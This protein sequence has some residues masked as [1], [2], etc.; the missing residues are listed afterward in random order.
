MSTFRYVL[1]WFYWLLGLLCA[2]VAV[3][4]L[5]RFI[6]EPTPGKPPTLDLLVSLG[7][8]G[9]I[10]V[11]TF[12]YLMA[13]WVLRGNSISGK[14]WVIVASLINL[15][16]ALGFSFLF[17]RI[18][19]AAGLW[20]G[21]K[22]FAIPAAFGI[23][24]LFAFSTSSNSQELS[25]PSAGPI[26]PARSMILVIMR[27]W[28]R[29]LIV[30]PSVLGGAYGVLLASHGVYRSYGHIRTESVYF[31]FL[32]ICIF[33]IGSSLLYVHD[34]RRVKPI[35][36]ALALQIPSVSLRAFEYK[37]AAGLNLAVLFG[38]PS[39]AGEG[40]L[41]LEWV[42]NIGIVA[43]FRFAQA[44]E[45]Q[46]R[47]GVNLFAAVLFIVLLLSLQRQSKSDMVETINVRI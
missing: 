30:L 38:L 21:I 14:R 20:S 23:A 42:Q 13:W 9:F 31:A 11:A 28:L 19:G 8:Y 16:L 15:S 26:P 27:N 45:G 2:C 36:I 41:P 24:S 10:L 1:S 29:L 33:I 47:I 18:G 40:V 4:V 37:L 25:P 3:F 39:A 35:L 32:A 5:P 17:L 7:M 44:F 6:F 34:P 22:L 46:S 43:S 12:V